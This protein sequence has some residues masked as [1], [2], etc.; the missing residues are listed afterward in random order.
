MTTPTVIS[1]DAE[2][3]IGGQKLRLK[4][5]VPAGE[6]PAEALLPLARLLSP[7]AEAK[8]P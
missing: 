8:A 3:R 5:V 2:L 1:A 6:V 7:A 4:L